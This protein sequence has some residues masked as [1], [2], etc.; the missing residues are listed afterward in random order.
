MPNSE[1]AHLFTYNYFWKFFHEAKF[2]LQS[3]GNEN[4]SCDLVNYL[5]VFPY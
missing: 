3:L 2:R 5:I 1:S 4:K